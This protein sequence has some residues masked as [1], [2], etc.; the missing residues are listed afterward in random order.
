M[1]LLHRFAAGVAFCAV[2][3]F[4]AGSAVADEVWQTNFEAAKA[5]A[6]AEHKLLLVEFS[7][8]DW[9]PFCKKMKAG[10]V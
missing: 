10:R 5:R 3:V 1:A 2:V 9:C 4:V 6:K 7:G 8:S